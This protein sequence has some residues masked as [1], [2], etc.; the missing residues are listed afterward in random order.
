MSCA[1]VYKSNLILM[2]EKGEKQYMV[3]KLWGCKKKRFIYLKALD[4][5]I[6]ILP[7][8]YTGPGVGIVHKNVSRQHTKKAP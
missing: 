5:V 8:A 7:A 6:N 3:I 1:Y 2:Y 4:T